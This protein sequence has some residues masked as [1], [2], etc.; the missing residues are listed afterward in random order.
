M[1]LGARRNTCDSVLG[2]SCIFKLDESKPGHKLD[3]TQ[4]AKALEEA[5]KVSFLRYIVRPREQILVLPSRGT[6]P[7]YTRVSDK[8]PD[9]V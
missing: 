6:R 9:I 3:F 7:M 2:I 8:G 1:L 5:F 4:L